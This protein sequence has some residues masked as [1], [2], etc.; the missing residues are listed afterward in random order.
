M[1]EGSSRNMQSPGTI[2]KGSSRNM[3]SSVAMAKGSSRN[4]LSSVGGSVAGLAPGRGVENPVTSTEAVAE[5]QEAKNHMLNKVPLIL[6]A[7]ICG[8][9]LPAQAGINA[10]LAPFVGSRIRAAFA[11]LLTG[12]LALLPPSAVTGYPIRQAFK[13]IQRRLRTDRADF[14]MFFG[15]PL[16]AFFVASG[17]LLSPIIGFALFFVAIV[18]GQLIVSLVYDATGWY[19]TPKRPVGA[20]QVLGVALA[21]GGAVMFQADELVHGD[22]DGLVFGLIGVVAGGLLIVQSTFNKRLSITIGSP[23]RGAFVSFLAGSLALFLAAMIESLVFPAP[24]EGVGQGSEFWM[25]LGGPIG[26]FVVGAAFIIIPSKIGFVNTFSSVVLGQ[27]A[28]GLLYDAVDAF[29]LGE[30]PVTG[31]RA[32][33]IVTVLV[34]TVLVSWNSPVE[35]SVGRSDRANQK[36]SERKLGFGSILSIEMAGGL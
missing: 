31:L 22:D 5:S 9:L 10:N 14:L 29:G 24:L 32:G 12:T 2:A 4:T 15:G 27:L 18:T 25:W 7:V 33:G 1:A 3:L 13:N 26:A 20:V 23:W 6:V 30:R 28:G 34:G 16:G 11:S 19:H 35:T 21:L 36:P 17:V 8:A